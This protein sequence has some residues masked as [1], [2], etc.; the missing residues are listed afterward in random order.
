MTG[1]GFLLGDQSLGRRFS[2]IWLQ[3]RFEAQN[4]NHASTFLATH[5][6][7][8]VKIWLFFILFSLHF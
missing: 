3:T 7:P 1:T 8:N 2:Q 5:Q 4:C 6:K